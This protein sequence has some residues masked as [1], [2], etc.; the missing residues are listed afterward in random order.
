MIAEM[1]ARAAEDPRPAVVLY[2]SDFDPSGWQMPVS[3]S[4]KLQALRTLRHPDLRIAVHPVALTLDQVRDLNLPSTPLKETEKR[5][6]KWRARMGH[7]Q[8]EIDALGGAAARGADPHRAR[9][10]EAVLRFH[11]R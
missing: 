9:C 7:E 1:A 5:A 10:A 2:F 3:V 6:D 11:A 4:R 8:T